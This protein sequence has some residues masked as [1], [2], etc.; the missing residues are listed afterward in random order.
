[1]KERVDPIQRCFLKGYL[2]TAYGG[3]CEVPL[4]A[5]VLKITSVIFYQDNIPETPWRAGAF[6]PVKK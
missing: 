3:Y 1:M 4:E 2:L 6:F 5:T